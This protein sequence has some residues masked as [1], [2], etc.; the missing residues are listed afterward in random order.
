MRFFCPIGRVSQKLSRRIFEIK[1]NAW[2]HC[3]YISLDYQYQSRNWKS[4]FHFFASISNFEKMSSFSA[5]TSIAV[6]RVLWISFH[7]NFIAIGRGQKIRHFFV[8]EGSTQ[9]RTIWSIV[10]IRTLWNT[11]LLRRWRIK[12]PIYDCGYVRKSLYISESTA[13]KWM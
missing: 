1:T 10:L 4:I 5:Q 11:T 6:I 7:I 13:W 2:Y 3:S 12:L 8:S 9:N